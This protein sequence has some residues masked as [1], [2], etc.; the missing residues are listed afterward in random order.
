MSNIMG[1]LVLFFGVALA[2]LAIGVVVYIIVVMIKKKEDKKFSF[3]I[4]PKALL[5]IYLYA[6]S[7]LTLG[8]A[9]IGLSTTIRATLS[10]PFGIQFSYTLQRAND[11]TEA[12]KFDTTV[13]PETFQECYQG[14]VQTLNGTDFCVDTSQRKT[15]LI[16]GITLFVSMSI[17]F[18]I[19]QY[20][21]SK[22]EKKK[23]LGWLHKFYTFAG[24]ILYS[25]V[26][27]IAIPTSIYQLT[28]Y[29]LFEPD[30]SIYSTPQA[31][32]MAIAVTVIALPLWIYFLQKTMNLK[33][34]KE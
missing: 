5:Q 24:L 28:N 23:I 2:V 15:D 22:I 17:L 31:P 16:N 20:A 13:K 7:F 9:V 6:I 1:F 11:L 34:D 32:A 30:T 10:Y 8:I 4:S 14:E 19:H 29:L 25:I 21:I 27:I 33:E 3:K 18:A 26:S 12:Q